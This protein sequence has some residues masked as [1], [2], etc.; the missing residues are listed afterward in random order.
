MTKKELKKIGTFTYQCLTNQLHGGEIFA[1]IWKKAK[2]KKEFLD[3]IL[4]DP[5][6]RGEQGTYA[7]IKEF[8]I[9]R[10]EGY[11]KLLIADADR[12]TTL[13]DAGGVR[14]GN[15]DY[16]FLIPNGIGDGETT[17]AIMDDNC[18][19]CESAFQYFTLIRG[20]FFVYSHDGVGE[21]VKKLE[22]GFM[23]FYSDGIIVFKKIPSR[24]ICGHWIV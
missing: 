20:E 17:V 9:E 22:G 2:T 6:V 3:M 18:H 16:S 1:R 19:F 7:A 12:F 11:R 13:S 15:V 10:M 8:N 23:V 21:A 24:R 14:I 4:D 5:Q